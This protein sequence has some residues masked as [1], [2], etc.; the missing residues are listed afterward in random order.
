MTPRTRRRIT[1]FAGI[2]A[3]LAIICTNAPTL[4]LFGQRA[5][6]EYLP[7]SKQGHTAAVFM[8]GDMGLAM[9]ISGDIAKGLAGHGLP[10]TG[11]SSPVA[12]ARQLDRAQ[13]VAIVRQAVDE[14]LARPGI[15]KVMLVGQSFGSDIIA[16]VAPDLP[17]RQQARIAG[18]VLVVPS[19][20]VHFRADPSGIAYMGMPDATPAPALRTLNWAPITCIQG[21]EEEASLCPML[22]GTSA[23]RIVLPGNHYLRRDA[24]R[25][26]ATVLQAIGNMTASS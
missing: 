24:P 15:D 19:N 22:G 23:R 10:V 16:T 9:G 7:A 14:A 26:L 3:A 6:S 18:I 13:T 2:F 8:S 20:N 4:G 21:A 12:F 17:P 5:T 11:I 1:L 25:V